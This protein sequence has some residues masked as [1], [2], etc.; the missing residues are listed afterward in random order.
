MIKTIIFDF[1]DV[2]R[3]DSYKGWLKRRGQL[4][5]GEYLDVNKKM[6]RGEIDVRGFME[7]LSR[8]TG[9][10][11]ER[12]EEDME[13]ATKIDYDVLTL[14]EGLRRKGY[15][16]GL[17]SNA[18]SEFIRDILTQHDLEKYFDTIVISS[19]VGLIKPEPEIFH[20]ILEKMDAH[21]NETV[22]IDDNPHNVKAAEALG[23]EGIIFTSASALEKDFNHLGI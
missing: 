14:I 20:H 11:I 6:D 15:P 19:E 7:H 21:P 17:L 4:L 23:I 9:Q 10:T 2:I 1:F 18:P 16:I 8:L 22:F 5:E 3:T 13:A 12:I